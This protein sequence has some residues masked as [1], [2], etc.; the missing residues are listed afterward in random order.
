MKQLTLVV[1]Y[2][3]F[4][5]LSAAG[6]LPWFLRL[7]RSCF[8]A[9]LFYPVNFILQIAENAERHRDC[10]S[11]H[12]RCKFYVSSVSHASDKNFRRELKAAEVAHYLISKIHASAVQPQGSKLI[13]ITPDEGARIRAAVVTRKKSLVLR[14]NKSEIYRHEIY[15]CGCVKSLLHCR[16]LYD[17]ILPPSIYYLGLADKY[18]A[19][20]ISVVVSCPKCLDAYRNSLSLVTQLHSR[21]IHRSADALHESRKRRRVGS[22]LIKRKSPVK[23][24]AD[25]SRI[26]RV[27]RNHHCHANSMQSK[28]KKRQG[29]RT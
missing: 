12:Q 11:A 3:V 20:Q 14:E 1:P 17:K 8:F 5:K 23:N 7:V 21:I 10:V 22:Y 15:L 9:Q 28:V 19:V 4:V 27:K 16:Q 25:F 18:A 26:A 24:S 13:I 2:L 6:R 29:V